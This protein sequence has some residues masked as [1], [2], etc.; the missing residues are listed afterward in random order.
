MRRWPARASQRQVVR[1]LKRTVGFSAR[2]ACGSL[3][4]SSRRTSSRSIATSTCSRRG[5]ASTRAS[6]LSTSGSFCL[7]SALHACLLAFFEARAHMGRSAAE[8][9]YPAIKRTLMQ[10]E[11]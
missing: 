4:G 3:S 6:I 5:S 9:R 2:K 8:S 7:Q 11:D 10:E 1:G